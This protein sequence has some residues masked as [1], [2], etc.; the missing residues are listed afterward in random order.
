M[1]CQ[2]AGQ[3]YQ[4]KGIIVNNLSKSWNL[5][6]V[7]QVAWLNYLLSPLCFSLLSFLFCTLLISTILDLKEKDLKKLKHGN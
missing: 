5:K 6:I 4:K 2:V 3:K 1:I 7:T